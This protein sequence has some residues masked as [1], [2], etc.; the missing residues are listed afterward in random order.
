M[1]NPQLQSIGSTLVAFRKEKGLTQAELA[2]LTNIDRQTISAIERGQF[3]GSLRTL[4]RYL[5]FANFRLSISPGESAY[6]TLEELSSRYG[7]DDD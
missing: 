1:S 2:K 5:Q 7:D 4:I 6:P 3:T